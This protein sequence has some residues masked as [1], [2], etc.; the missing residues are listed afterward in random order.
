MESIDQNPNKRMT[1]SANNKP[2]RRQ[3]YQGTHPRTFREKYKEHQP[4]K[5]TEDV[6][7]VMASGKTPAGSHRPIMVTEILQQLAPRPGAVVVDCTLGYGGHSREL[8]TAV[9]PGGKLLAVDV[10]PIE[11]IKT[12]ARLRELGFPQQSLVVKRMNYAGVL[13]FVLSEAPDGADAILADLGLSSMQID[14]P[15]RGF[16]FKFDGP[17][18]MRMNP[19]HG[20]PVSTLLSTFSEQ[21]LAKL[22]T[23][24]ADEPRAGLLAKEILNAHANEPLASTRDLAEVITRALQKGPSATSDLIKETT[25]RVFQALRI[26]ANDEFGALDSFLRQL[27]LCLKP[28]GRVAIMSFHSG[29]DR[30]VKQAFKAGLNEGI[31]CSISENVIRASAEEQRI[32]PRSAPAKLRVATKAS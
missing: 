3:R 21:A 17:M 2:P 12:E 9:Q 8:L 15:E 22:L 29:E 7:K 5:Y 25:R 10:D 19:E 13:Y 18:D 14:N 16:T 30:R 26:A 27:P 6:A 23:N 24:N 11:I 20:Q 4:D 28:G 1:D 31:Y 32:N